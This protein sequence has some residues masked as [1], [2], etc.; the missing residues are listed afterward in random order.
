MTKPYRAIADRIKADPARAAE[1]EAEKRTIAKA[2]ALAELRDRRGASQRELARTMGV[3]Q[4]NISRVEHED[5]IYLS[6]LD[7]YV[8]A[9]GGRLEIRAVFPDETVS[10]YVD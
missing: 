9:L 8:R 7:S 10:L 6:S 3:S 1:I 4:A 2:L 5:D